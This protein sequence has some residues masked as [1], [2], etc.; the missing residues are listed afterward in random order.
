MRSRNAILPQAARPSLD[1]TSQFSHLGIRQWESALRTIFILPFSFE[2]EEKERCE[3]N[4]NTAGAH[5]TAGKV[6]F[7]S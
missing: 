1:S 3:R 7:K 2:K 6:L 4:G 5:L